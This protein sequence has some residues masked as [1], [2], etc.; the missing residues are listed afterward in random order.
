M[1][2]FT[3]A[4]NLSGARPG[5]QFDWAA[6]KAVI[7]GMAC[8]LSLCSI[9]FWYLV[10]LSEAP[11]WLCWFLVFELVV[12]NFVPA[13]FE[14]FFGR[15]DPFDAK[16]LF[17]VYYFLAFSLPSICAVWLGFDPTP[18]FADP[19]ASEGLQ[20]RALSAILL[21]LTGFVMGCYLPIGVVVGKMIPRISHCSTSI[22]RRVGLIG[23][24]IGSVAF[25]ILMRSAGGV[26][27]FIENLGTWRTMGVL[28]GIGY[29]TF[30]ITCILPASV[31]LLFLQALPAPNRHLNRATLETLALMV[32]CCCGVMILGFR[33]SLVPIILSFLAAW[34]YARR[35]FRISRLVVLAFGL[36]IFLTIFGAIRDASDS[37]ISVYGAQRALL[38][39]VP[40][41]DTVERVISRSDLGEPRRGFTPMLLESA[42]ILVPRAIWA[43]KPETACLPFDDAFFDDFFLARGDPI[44][45]VRSGVSTTLIGESYWIAGLPFVFLCPFALGI[46]SVVAASWRNSGRGNRLHIFLYALFFGSFP[47][48]VEVLQNALN[49]FT[50]IGLMSLGIVFVV[51]KFRA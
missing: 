47:L 49:A 17:L 18:E 43:E 8:V 6:G 16:H 2:A 32:I 51:T 38:F 14:I 4:H 20:A 29:L 48:F 19:R 15:F 45:A 50:M 31:L 30:P 34:H 25:V 39:R 46:F 1:K 7:L 36:G 40:G 22:E 3:A 5:N 35:A 33:S 24:L 12:L 11:E 21:G 37:T 23:V 9:L 28:G 44:D 42:T 10:P 27:S 13:V 26:R 41:L